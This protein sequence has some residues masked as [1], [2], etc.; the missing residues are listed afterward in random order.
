MKCAIRAELLRM[1]K[2]GL[3]GASGTA[4][5]MATAG[6]LYYIA[7]AP[8]LLSTGIGFETSTLWNFYFHENWT[9]RDLRRPAGVAARLLKFHVSSLASLLSQLAFVFVLHDCLGVE[10]AL[11]LLVGIAGGFILNYAI[12]RLYTWGSARPKLKEGA[13]K[14]P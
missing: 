1:L 4:V 8:S 11:S 2:F 9:F 6:A 7:G 3:V 5:N 10:Y 14:S 12:S 13:P